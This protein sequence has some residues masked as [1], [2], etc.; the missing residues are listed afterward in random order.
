MRQLVKIFSITIFA[1]FLSYG[2]LYGQKR[3]KA[4]MTSRIVDF[5]G[6]PVSHARIWVQG[7]MA[8]TDA[9]GEFTIRLTS[10][11]EKMIRVEAEHFEPLTV[12]LDTVPQG[13]ALVLRT[14]PFQLGSRDLVNIPF[15]KV[16]KRDIASTVTVI[17][18]EDILPYDNKQGVLEALRGRVPGLFGTTNVNGLGNALVVVDGIPMDAGNLR[19]MEVQ[20]IVVLRDVASRIMYGARADQ[21]VILITTKHGKPYRQTLKVTG[22]YGASVP[23]SYPDYLPAADYMTMYNEALA[24]DGVAPKYDSAT[25]SNTRNK[26][27][28]ILYPDESYYNSIYL[29]DFSNSFTLLSE[30]SGGN[31]NTQYYV[32]MGWIRNEG[33]LNVGQGKRESYNRLNVRSNVDFHLNDYL[34]MN[35]G[36]FVVYNFN[37]IPQGDFWGNAA[38]FHPDWYPVLI[39]SHYVQDSAMLAA[40]KFVDRDKLLGGTTEHQTNI[41]GDLTLAG[42]RNVTKRNLEFHTGLNLDLGFLT[43]GLSA[44]AYFVFNLYN[45]FAT[46]QNNT[47]A[48]YQP[49]VVPS[50]DGTDSLVFTKINEDVKQGSQSVTSSD[51]YRK[52]GFF[53]TINYYKVIKQHKINITGLAYRNQEQYNNELHQNRYLNFG[54]QGHYSYRDK[55]LAEVSGLLAGSPRFDKSHRFS[56]SPSLALGWVASEEDF[57]KDNTVIDFLKLNT[58]VGLL[59]TDEGVTDYYLYETSYESGGWYNYENGVSRNRRRTVSYLGNT[60]LSWVKRFETSVGFQMDLFHSIWLEANYLYS[61]S[62]DN[63]TMRE[64]YYPTLTGGVYPYENYNSYLEQGVSL[65]MNYRKKIDD[66]SF[67]VGVTMGYFVP[68]VLKIDEPHYEV[69]YRYKQGHPTDARFGLVAEGLFRDSTD[70][71]NHA[72]QT[73]GPVQPGDIKYKDLNQDGIIDNNDQKII[74]NYS[75]RFQY[76]INL[77]LKYKNWSLYFLGTGQT[78]QESYF[79]NDYYWVYGDKKY[80]TVVLGRWTPETAATATYPRLSSRSNANNFRNSTFWLYKNNWFTLHTA[81]LSYTLSEKKAMKTIFK[82]GLQVYLRGSNLFTISKIRD[83]RELNIGSSPQ[84]RLYA[85]GLNVIF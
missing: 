11:K 85:V 74:G 15:G 79:N 36:G 55:Y 21:P 64:N 57:L 49:G 38:T 54:I 83:K 4:T 45:T 82:K 13:K 23:I 7:K 69:D 33:L 8:V 28:P 17:N 29:K 67:N 20:H 24:N 84:T 27:N 63:I 16:M 61:K 30:A 72:V 5:Q 56:F 31:E 9:N 77:N 25:I 60:N 22:E 65:G 19:L 73:F 66:L 3:K 14:A 2:L 68:K 81:Q 26:T 18:P 43:E 32:N 1:I 41:Y 40:A 53:G 80:S 70:I 76:G 75:S 58:T 42:Y 47:Y 51:F 44:K 39:P 34:K 12:D 37:K 62:F 59:N 78:G 10:G 6:N 52:I 71:L 50:Y 46:A 35:I 48:V